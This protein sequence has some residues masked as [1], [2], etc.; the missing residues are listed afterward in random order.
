VVEA[1]QQARGSRTEAAKVLGVPR[2]TLLNK[3]KRYGLM[4]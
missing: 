4:K 2:T 3:I 1:L